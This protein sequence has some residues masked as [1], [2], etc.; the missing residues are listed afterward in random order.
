MR[1]AAFVHLDL[2]LRM[3]RLESFDEAVERRRLGAGEEGQERPRLR[4][5]TRDDLERDLG[6]V[7]SAR[8]RL[9]VREAE[10]VAAPDRAGR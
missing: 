2:E 5:Q 7:V 3:S 9:A 10:P 1:L 6:E 8:D 4:E